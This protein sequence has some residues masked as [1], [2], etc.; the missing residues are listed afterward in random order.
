MTVLTT[1]LVDEVKDLYQE[2]M[3]QARIGERYGVTASA[4][5]TFMRINGIPTRSSGWGGRPRPAAASDG[6]LIRSTG[7]ELVAPDGRVISTFSEESDAR[8][9]LTEI[10]RFDGLTPEAREYLLERTAS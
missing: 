2:G 7:F 10:R 8:R 3:S 9:T 4:V 6:Y 5:S 1:E